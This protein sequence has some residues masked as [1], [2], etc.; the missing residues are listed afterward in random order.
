MSRD[1]YYSDF[2]G[3]GEWASHSILNPIGHA[4]N[5][6]ICESLGHMWERLSFEEADKSEIRY[7]NCSRCHRAEHSVKGQWKVVEIRPSIA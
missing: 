6:A 7:R 1:E 5:R 3:Y 4:L 2:D